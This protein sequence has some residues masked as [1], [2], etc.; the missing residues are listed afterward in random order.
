MNNPSTIGEGV[1]AWTAAAVVSAAGLAGVGALG[2]CAW[3]GAR[4][5]PALS[6]ALDEPSSA[7]A[8]A[9]A[10]LTTNGAVP[11]STQMAA[12]G[13]SVVRDPAMTP[14]GVGTSGAMGVSTTAT[15]STNVIPSRPGKLDPF[16]VESIAGT[17]RDVWMSPASNAGMG[18]SEPAPTG[19]NVAGATGAAMG[20]GTEGLTQVTFAGEGADFDPSVSRDGTWMVY[21]STQHRATADIYSKS[22]S[23]RTVTQLT[24]DPAHDI[25]PTISPDG[26]RVAFA[27]NRNGNWDIFVM[28]ASGGQAVQVSGDPAH[29]L[30]PSWSPDGTKLVFCRLGAI[31]GRWEMW[32]MDVNSSG[33]AEF[34]GF[35][36]FPRWCPKAGTAMGGKD[37]ILFQRSRERGG[38][39]FGVW[40]LDY[41]MG[42]AGMPTQIAASPT[43]AYINPAWSAD[44]TRI[45]FASVENGQGAASDLWTC[46]IDGSGL[47]NLT[48]G[49]KFTNLMPWWAGDGRIYFVSDRS[50]TPNLWSIGTDKAIQAAT[51]RS[52]SEKTM[53]TEKSA[54]QPAEMVHV[55]ES[56]PSGGES[57]GH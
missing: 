19:A 14:P 52:P 37:K 48:S 44:G 47:V 56:A 29:E 23:G 50:G 34:I 15:M 40:T 17:S 13:E 53:M 12:G 39:A 24:S 20:D 4:H 1:R 9:A 33:S 45:V 18:A 8:P 36:L 22:I 38:R 43:S 7:A 10:G 5:D 2:G 54:A 11:L 28:S 6:S 41:A 3:S 49:A 42:D 57:G 46:G 27:S 25:T 32:V 55:E 35:G 30:H 51:G 21:A 16:W 26:R 31:S